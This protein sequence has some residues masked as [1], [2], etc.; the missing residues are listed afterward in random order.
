[1]REMSVDEF[2]RRLRQL[3]ENEVMLAFFLGAGA[4]ISSGIPGASVL[5]EHWLQRLFEIERSESEAFE[6]WREGNVGGFD[7]NNPAVSYSTVMRRLFP[8][9]AERQE[10]IERVVVGR[11]P[12]FAYTSLAQ[13][14][15]HESHGPRCNIVLTT[16]F[17]DL[18][19]DALYLFTRVK[20]L[21]VTHEALVGYAAVGRSRPTII[22]LHG[23]A[24]LEPR[25]IDDELAELPEAIIKALEDHLR[26]RALVFIGYGGHD[27]GVT[28]ALTRLPDNIITHGI[29]WIG[30]QVPANRLGSWLNDHREAFWVN[31]L[32][33]DELMAVVK[34]EFYLP[35]PS[36]TR[37][38][39]L[40]GVYRDTFGRLQSRS[41]SDIGSS[42]LVARSIDTV[43][44]RFGNWF[45]VALEAEKFKGDFDRVEGI[46]ENGLVEF[47]S[48]PELL[49]SYALFLDRDRKDLDRAEAMYKRAIEADPTHA[50]N[51]A[52]YAYFLAWDRKE[53]DRAEAMYKRA[54]EADPTD[55]NVLGGYALFLAWDRKELDR[56]EAMYKRAI[57]ADPTNANAL[58]ATPFSWR[59]TERT[60]IGPRPCTSGRSKPI[61]HMPT[62]WGATPSSWTGTERTSIGP[63]PCTSGR[64]QPIPHM[65][66]TWGTTPSA[67][68]VDG[69]MQGH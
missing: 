51:L 69:T 31:H 38:D 44:I 10:E 57:E 56:A 59:G 48:S 47:P 6:E 67:Y 35:D 5:T 66:T 16:N 55:A 52:N 28:N 9:R 11:D 49:G 62:P 36:S 14:L 22:K 29:Y 13:L 18:L 3:L 12:G 25:N 1:M 19:A 4:S 20:P 23:D 64:S 41:G 39:D 68:S 45:S 60:S 43:R 46:Y 30:S 15:T 17:D 8:T 58:G 37:F 40:V 61:P 34:S 65:A 33:F 2:V 42:S 7:P 24:M 63:R 32:D 26:S 27:V 21:V 50:N 53:L 54:I